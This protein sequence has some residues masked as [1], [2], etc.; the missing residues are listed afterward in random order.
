LTRSTEFLDLI[1]STGDTL[2][3]QAV[4]VVAM[5]A[6]ALLVAVTTPAEVAKMH[7]YLKTLP[8]PFVQSGVAGRG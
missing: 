7:S 3:L 5:T 4:V 6:K 2:F 1:F 8:F